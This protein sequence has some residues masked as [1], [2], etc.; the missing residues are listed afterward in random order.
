VVARTAQIS[1]RRTGTGLRSAEEQWSDL[2]PD[3]TSAPL[4]G[5]RLRRIR[6]HQPVMHF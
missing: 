6:P 1:A 2:L 3:P 4:L 5:R